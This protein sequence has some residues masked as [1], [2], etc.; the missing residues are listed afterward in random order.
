[1]MNP[2]VSELPAAAEHQT[3]WPWKPPARAAAQTCGNGGSWP[4]ISV[5]TPSY[6]Q[7]QFLEE[8]IRSVL[9]QGYPNLEYIVMDDGSTDS[10]VDVLRK[11]DR[12]L[13]YWVSERDRGQTHAIN[14]GLARASGDIAAY[15]NSD[16]LYLPGALEH[17]ARVFVK[18][19][20]D[21]FVGQRRAMV[22]PP[23][24]FG[25]SWWRERVRN[26]VYPYIFERN[27]RYELPQECVFWSH[28]KYGGLQMDEDYHYCMDVW[29]F[30]HIYSGARV[31]HSSRPIGFFRAHGAN[32]SLQGE[33]MKQEIDRL[34]TL[35]A[36]YADRVPADAKRKILNAYHRAS[37]TA[38]VCHSLAPWKEQLFEYQH[39]EYFD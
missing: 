39:P 17:V 7:G 26:F 11:Y 3:G 35:L 28:R 19:G 37:R 25:R 22:Q 4:R 24:P 20:C 29:W 13:T 23:F 2:A 14:K 31:A 34:A 9:L 38:S 36:P 30:A 10:S 32:K 5:V 6:N 21:I 18:T 27:C 8:T 12:H 1:M 33:R 16:D 15:L